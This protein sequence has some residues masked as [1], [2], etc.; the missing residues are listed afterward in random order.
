MKA[1]QEY[2]NIM[3]D[4]VKK[5][6]ETQEDNIL[7]AA[8]V[9]TECTKKGGMI[10]LFGCGHSGLITEDVFWRAATLANVHAI[11]EGCVAGINE[12]TKSSHMEKVEGMG[13][14]IV[15]YQRIAPPDTMIVI[16]NSGNNAV[17]IEVAIASQKRGIPVIVLTNV[18]YSDFLSTHHSSGKKLKDYADVV[19]DNCSLIGDAAVELEGLPVKVGSTSTIPSVFLLNSILLQTC[20]NLLKQGVTPDVYYNGHLT[21]EMADAKEHND[22]LIDKYFYKIRNL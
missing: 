22:R 17:S 13:E 2:F 12:M 4:V 8:D 7:K 18:E 11:F 21:Y 14:I 19:V 10:H 1:W 6:E 5:A 9:L 15:D 16:S 20:D 3:K